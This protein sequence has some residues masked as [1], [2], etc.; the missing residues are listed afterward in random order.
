MCR[1]LKCFAVPGL[2]G[3]VA[4]LH[5]DPQGPSP[6]SPAGKVEF[7]RDILPIVSAHC[8]TCHGPDEKTRK[9]GL[10][11][12]L[13][14]TA[15]KKLKS[16]AR[17]VVPGDVKSSELI[18]RI[19]A[20]DPDERMPPAKTQ[21]SLK[22]TEKALLKRWIE[23]GAVY[24]KHWA[25][26]APKRPGLPAVRNEAWVKNSIDRFVLARLEKEGLKPA[27]A[28]D[29][30]T[31]A[32]RVTLDLTGLPPTIDAVDRFVNDKRPDA[33]ERFVDEVLKAPAYGERWAHVWLDL[34]RYADSNGYAT[35]S[36]RTIWKYRDWV[37]DALNANM[38]FDRFTLEQIAGDM[39]P[40][41]TNEQI[42]ATAF[43]RNT[44]TNDEGGTSDEEFRVAA[45][46]DRVNTTL[47]VWMGI[48]MACAQCHD[49]KYDPI[50]Q[51][52]YFR[53]FAVFNQTEDSD[54]SDN[55]PLLSSIT[56]EQQKQKSKLESDIAAL[57]K[58][59]QKPSPDL[60]M[61]QKQWEKDV[62]TDKLPGNVKAILALD[63]AKRNAAQQAE[64][65]KYFRSIAPELKQTQDQ[66]GALK[67]QLTAMPIVTTPIMKELPDSKKR[68][69]KIH[70]RG[71]FLDQGREVQPGVP[72]FLPQLDGKAQANRL[73]VARWLV[74][75]ENP[76]TARVAVNRFWEQLF[77]VGLMDTPDDFG[78]RGKLPNHPELL[79][80]L[81]TEFAAPAQPADGPGWDM[82]KLLRLIAT[83]ATYR[84][85]SAVTPALFER[86][87]DNKLSARGPR[88]RV[89]AEVIRDQALFISGLLSPKM[90]GTPVRPPRPK[91]GL[92]AAFGGGT[93]WETSPG[94]DKHRRALYTQWRRTSP[95]PSMTTFDAPSRNVCTVTRPRTNTP[96]QALVT[97]ND[98]VYVEAAQALGRR[99]VKEGGATTE[100]RV[101]YGFRLCL[102]RPPQEKEVQR[103]AAMF[104]QARNG[105]TNSPAD[106]LK[107]ATEPL[108]PLAA[109]QDAADMA[110]WTLVGNVLLNLDE[111]LAKR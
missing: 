8:F 65:T 110:A 104:T 97:L 109:G 79:D 91:L 2:F 5:A 85:S 44:L 43:H 88:F 108:G 55:S 22:D 15:M 28:A 27:P 17:A 75:P 70:I 12:D 76:L 99:M 92:T 16:G 68:V 84:Q 61:K 35:D 45:V 6:A 105:Y 59:L 98:P 81:A 14:E 26:V 50:S 64:L 53:V 20:T 67:K 90:H 7:A 94:E 40:G 101:T 106:A 77:G 18:A 30:H 36:L 63:A 29:R 73:A 31:L 21:K 19:F 107:L 80:W 37:I 62:K 24:Q 10:R 102:A 89:P 93:D 83:S 69:T 38:P 51:E 95:Y 47:Q 23:E 4:V 48:T 25:F 9:A 52:E 86:D 13:G 71:N 60:D 54:K 32:R 1:T 49:H 42:L 3:L 78:I 111:T 96:L 34:A 100:S 41:A 58:E 57:E 87:P 56:V 74:S 66:L 82:K 11:L 39:L 46:V 103:L 33:Y 72:M